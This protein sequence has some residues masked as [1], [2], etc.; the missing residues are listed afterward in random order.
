MAESIIS[1][2][3]GGASERA[4]AYAILEATR[5]PALGASCVAALAAV[6]TVEV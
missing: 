4:T 3:S 5:D 2:L 1:S 6:L